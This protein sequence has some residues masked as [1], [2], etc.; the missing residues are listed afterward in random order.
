MKIKDT[1][2]KLSQIN[3]VDVNCFGQSFRDISYT[4][5]LNQNIVK[6]LI[7]VEP[8]TFGKHC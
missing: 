4:K 8:E 5:Y 1:Q 3:I 2:N 6:R 7:K